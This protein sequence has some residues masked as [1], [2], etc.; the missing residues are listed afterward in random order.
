MATY[1]GTTPADLDVTVEVITDTSPQLGGDL[2]LNG[3][4]ISP[5]QSNLA[6]GFAI[7]MAV[8]M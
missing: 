8:A 6:K 4:D 1:I 7:A 2:D 5:E 3:F